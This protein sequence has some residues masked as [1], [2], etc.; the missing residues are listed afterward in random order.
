M[1]KWGCFLVVSV[2]ILKQIGV[3]KVA[4]E[5]DQESSRGP[6][7]P[8]GQGGPLSGGEGVQTGP[9]KVSKLFREGS[10]RRFERK[11]PKTS[12]ML[13]PI[14]EN[15]RFLRVAGKNGQKSGPWWK[16]A[17]VSMQEASRHHFGESWVPLGP[18]APPPRRAR[19]NAGGGP[20]GH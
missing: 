6:K 17:S 15:A 14:N 19:R 2:D 7:R 8:Q 16:P 9:Q 4:T 3:P 13:T 11:K 20:E 10:K 1:T 12:K 5:G 18:L